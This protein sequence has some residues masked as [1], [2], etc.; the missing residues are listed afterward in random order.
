MNTANY[1][2]LYFSIERFFLALK[3][4]KDRALSCMFIAPTHAVQSQFGKLHSVCY[5]TS[6]PPEWY[7]VFVL[8]IPGCSRISNFYWV[9]L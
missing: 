5:L 2:S 7:D 8:S 9:N 6:W 1:Q 4:C 3:S